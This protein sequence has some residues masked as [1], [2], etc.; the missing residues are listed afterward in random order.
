L[1]TGLL[2]ESG[3]KD[4]KRSQHKRQNSPEKLHAGSVAG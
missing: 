4:Q 1:R 3:R 2:K